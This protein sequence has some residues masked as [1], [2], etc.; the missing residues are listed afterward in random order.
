MTTYYYDNILTWGRTK[1]TS[2]IVTIVNDKE[3]NLNDEETKYVR[4]K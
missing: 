3:Q 1:E 2:Y 4:Y